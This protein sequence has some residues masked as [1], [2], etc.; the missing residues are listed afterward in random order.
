MSSYEYKYNKYKSKYLELRSKIDQLTEH[1][2]ETSDN[3]LVLED[4]PT[5]SQVGGY[6]VGQG[7]AVSN[8]SGVPNAASC[9]A[10]V[11]VQP[12]V[13]VPVTPPTTAPISSTPAPALAPSSTPAVV[14]SKN[15]HTSDTGSEATTTELKSEVDKI[16]S[17][18]GGDEHY[19]P[20]DSISSSDE[21]EDS[22]GD[23]SS[24][25]FGTVYSP[26]ASDRLPPG[27]DNN[28]QRTGL[29]PG[30]APPF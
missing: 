9:A 29:A 4:T 15:L 3:E 27:N 11:N 20:F 21:L 23:S 28:G 25:N 6:S 16:Y 18:L 14:N 17:Q 13:S 24:D 12:N 30:D 26:I 8:L 19:D 7:A 1:N 2:I 5:I 10:S 22:S